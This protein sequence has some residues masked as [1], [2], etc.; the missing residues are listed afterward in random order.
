MEVSIFSSSTMA[1]G[2]IPFA[3]SCVRIVISS[4]R[5]ASGLMIMTFIPMVPS[6][7]FATAYPISM[8]CSADSPQYLMWPS[9]NFSVRWRSP[10]IFPA[11]MT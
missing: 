4:G 11:R 9:L 7:F 5:T 10:V 8:V 3:C 2:T 1:S 6:F